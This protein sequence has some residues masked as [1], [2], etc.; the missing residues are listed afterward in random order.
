M[1]TNCQD[2]NGPNSPYFGIAQQGLKEMRSLVHEKILESLS[3]K[4]GFNG[5]FQMSSMFP[6][7]D[8]L[9][10]DS[11]QQSELVS[12]GGGDYSRDNSDDENDE[13]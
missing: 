5:T 1:Y 2:Y 9:G 4:K 11:K 6:S 3:K 8:D 13:K 7:L 10:G 12:E